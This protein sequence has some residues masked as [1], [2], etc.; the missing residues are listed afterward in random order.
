MTQRL[1]KKDI[2]LLGRYSFDL[3][4]LV[5]ENSLLENV[6][7]LKNGNITIDFINEMVIYNHRLES[8]D[9]IKLVSKF[10]TAHRSKGLES[11]IVI[12]LNC[13]S[14]KYGFPSEVSDDPV[15]K[16]LLAGTDNY[17]NA[18]ER[19]LFYVAMTRAKEK[20]YMMS[21]SKLKSKFITE[22]DVD[23][24]ASPDT[25]KCPRCKTSDLVVRKSG[26]AVNGNSFEF[27]GCSNYL[28]GCDYTD[29]K[30]L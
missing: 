2:F 13:N 10:I 24:S 20:V 23:N 3:V 5:R 21:N 17:E 26:Q 22:L 8:G 19:R 6:R 29:T 9:E 12:I 7:T 15:L 28:F 1:S 25:L 16:L 11:D 18:E 4:R 30:W 14:G 27:Y